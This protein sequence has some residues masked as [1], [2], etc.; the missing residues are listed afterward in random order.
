MDPTPEETDPLLLKLRAEKERRFAQRVDAGEAVIVRTTVVS[1]SEADADLEKAKASAVEQHM[2]D[3]PWDLGKA[4][5]FDLV[6]IITGVPRSEGHGKWEA[7]PMPEFESEPSQP[8][9]LSPLY[10]PPRYEPEAPDDAE[11]S[12]WQQITA[13]LVPPRPDRSLLG[14]WSVRG[15]ELTLKFED[16]RETTV[17]AGANPERTARELLRKDH[18]ERGSS[19]PLTFPDWGV[20]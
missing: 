12:E 4:V 5:I 17:N 20:A 7:G 6:Q 18:A 9:P 8:E 1:E 3:N 19:G 15:R 10:G 16:G 2:K 14:W 11:P 13:Q